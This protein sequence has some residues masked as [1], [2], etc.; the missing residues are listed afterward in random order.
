MEHQT[1]PWPASTG[2]HLTA[3][4]LGQLVR[5]VTANV[6]PNMVALLRRAAPQH[7][8]DNIEPPL[9]IETDV[10]LAIDPID[11][12]MAIDTHRKLATLNRCG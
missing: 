7:G 4:R 9:G 10:G 2:R 8:V 1:K 3:Q 12:A 5:S 6:R 11:M